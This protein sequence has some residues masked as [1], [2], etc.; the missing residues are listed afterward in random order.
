MA[1][2]CQGDLSSGKGG[3]CPGIFRT[4]WEKQGAWRGKP[5]FSVQAEKCLG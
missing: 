1:V 4:L 2:P 3:A 5:E